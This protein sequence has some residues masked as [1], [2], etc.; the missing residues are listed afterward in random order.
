MIKNYAT[1]I[2]K[3][4]FI[5]TAY[6]STWVAYG[7]VWYYETFIWILKD[8]QRDDLIYTEDSGTDFRTALKNHGRLA[9]I[10]TYL[11]QRRLRTINEK[12]DK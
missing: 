3:Y 4:Y 5:S 7:E 11:E 2:N 9:K 8:N 1:N 12:R 6:R 10:F